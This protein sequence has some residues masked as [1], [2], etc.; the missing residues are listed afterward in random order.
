MMTKKAIAVLSG[1][2]DS[3]VATCVYAEDYE[4]HHLQVITKFQ[5]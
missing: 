3:C 2:L 1:G 4:I 5:L